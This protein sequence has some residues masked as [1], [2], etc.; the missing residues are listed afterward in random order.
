[1]PVQL[2]AVGAATTVL[3]TDCYLML[4]V[5][6]TNSSSTDAIPEPFYRLLESLT[7]AMTPRGLRTSVAESTR[8]N[9]ASSMSYHLY[10]LNGRQSPAHVQHQCFAKS[11]EFE[12]LL[13]SCEQLLPIMFGGGVIRNKK[14][15]KGSLIQVGRDDESLRTF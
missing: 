13:N 8:Y 4:L 9:E 5:R 6:T 10:V 14:L 11:F 12:R 3:Q 2:S 15:Q 1:M 7:N